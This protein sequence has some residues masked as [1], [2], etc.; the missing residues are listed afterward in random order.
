MSR[1]RLALAF[2]LVASFAGGAT[3]APSSMKFADP[4]AVEMPVSIQV[5]LDRAAIRAKLAKN[6]AANLARFRVYQRKGVFPNNTYT[7]GKLNVWRDAF[8]NLCAAATIIQLSGNADLVQRTGAQNNFIRLADVTD[9]PLMDWI[10]TSGLTQDEI[11]AIQEPMMRV[12][13]EPVMEP[14]PEPILVD[15]RMRRIEDRRLVRKYRQVD[16]QIVKHRTRSLDAATD[17]LLAN[18][19]LA[20]QFLASN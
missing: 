7:D 5:S 12:T 1:L 16:A 13:H 6:R 11:A 4:P 8:G 2:S 3:A 10:L 18:P 15:R 20:R 9:G 19:T 17:R 14:S